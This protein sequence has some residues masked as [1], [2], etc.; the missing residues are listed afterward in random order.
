LP[1]VED[2]A[3]LAL[4]S[5]QGFS[6]KAWLSFPAMDYPLSDWTE[7]PAFLALDVRR[8][9]ETFSSFVGSNGLPAVALTARP[10]PESPALQISVPPLPVPATSEFRLEGAIQSRRLLGN[11]EVPSWPHDDLLTNT[12][13]QVLVDDEGN[14]LSTALLTSS[15][16]KS[17]DNYALKQSA[18][19]RFEPVLQ[20]NAP[21]ARC[22]FGRL[23]FQWQTAPLSQTN[24]VSA[25]R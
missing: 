13:V 19:A 14:T 15:G 21:P 3:L 20:T 1:T 25:L 24:A 10:P 9:G 5:L 12:V 2:P 11:I 4:P 8:L 22:T 7:P 6:G 18:A 16:S 23:I 17:A